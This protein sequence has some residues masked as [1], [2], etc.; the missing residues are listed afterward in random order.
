MAKFHLKSIVAYLSLLKERKKEKPLFCS[1]NK[2]INN[3]FFLDI[4]AF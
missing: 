4:V 2:N 3:I 1:T